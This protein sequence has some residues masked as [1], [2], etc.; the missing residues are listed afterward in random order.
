MVSVVVADNVSILIQSDADFSE[1][2]A[3]CRWRTTFT[4]QLT[5]S[6]ISQFHPN[7]W[8]QTRL[9]PRSH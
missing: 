7:Y 2:N 4:A 5:W 1:P 6:P 9:R 8:H 3:V